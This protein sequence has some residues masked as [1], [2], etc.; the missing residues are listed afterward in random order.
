MFPELLAPRSHDLR[1]ALELGLADSEAT[2]FVG[3][4]VPL[5]VLGRV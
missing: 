2:V 3:F 1:G 5:C 4:L